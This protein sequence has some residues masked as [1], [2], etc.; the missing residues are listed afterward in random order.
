MKQ[1]KPVLKKAAVVFGF[2]CMGM[3]IGCST[4]K[5]SEPVAQNILNKSIDPSIPPPSYRA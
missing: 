1:L 2:F 5:N 3:L 4:T